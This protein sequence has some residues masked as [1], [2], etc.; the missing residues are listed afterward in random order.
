MNRSDPK[1]QKQTKDA[2][3]LRIAAG[4]DYWYGFAVRTLL[5]EGDLNE[6][7][8]YELEFCLGYSIELRA[9]RKLPFVNEA[10]AKLRHVLN[11]LGALDQK[12]HVITTVESYAGSVGVRKLRDYVRKLAFEKRQL[13]FN[14]G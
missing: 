9:D 7:Q 10:C 11:E 2:L 1:L 13:Q 6:A 4:L 8:L 14:Y 5:E 3:V 12:F